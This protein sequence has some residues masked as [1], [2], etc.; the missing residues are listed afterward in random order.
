MTPQSPDHPNPYKDLNIPNL[1]I[2]AKK[3]ACYVE[4]KIRSYLGNAS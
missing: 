3:M 4:D 2:Y 1:K